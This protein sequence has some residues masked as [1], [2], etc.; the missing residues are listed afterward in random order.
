MAAELLVEERDAVATIAF[1]RPGARNALSLAMIEEMTAA[2]ERFAQRPDL[3]VVVLRGA[4]DLPFS[5]GFDMTQLPSGSLSSEEAR[6]MHA[7]IRA[8]AGAIARC[9]HVVVGAARGFVFGA[10]FDLFLHC[11]LRICTHDTR[12]CLPPNRHG[13]LYPV[14]GVQRLA[15]MAG[16]ARAASMLLTGAP[17]GAAEA[18]ADGIVQQQVAPQRFD[19]ELEALCAVLAANAPLSMRETKRTLQDLARGLAP[20]DEQEMYTR[21]AACLNSEDVREAMAAFRGKR[22][23]VFRGR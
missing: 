13:F 21:I 2:L 4:R 18:L 3:R 1:D 7:P 5:A 23:P 15:A 9:P 19:Q 20:P 14:E 10:A 22:K 17:V 11:D 16:Q 6:A 12:F 8:V